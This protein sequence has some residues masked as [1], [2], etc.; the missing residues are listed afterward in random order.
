MNGLINRYF[1]FISLI[2]SFWIGVLGA[3]NRSVEAQMLHAVIIADISAEAGW[4]ELGN[5]AITRD[6]FSILVAIENQ[7]PSGQLKSNL[8]LLRDRNQ[9]HPNEIAA[10]IEETAITPDDIL[11]LYYSGHGARDD[12]GQFL[13]LAS[14]KLYRQEIA[15][16]CGW[17]VRKP[18]FP[19]S[20][21][22]NRKRSAHCSAHFS[23][24]KKAG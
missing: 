12:N 8:L 3:L 4:G 22:K 16:I 5:T 19:K 1:F 10:A 17:M 23:F 15:A 6:A 2:G 21:P 11:F 13:Q 20:P 7:V 18:L 14:G 24:R 9:S